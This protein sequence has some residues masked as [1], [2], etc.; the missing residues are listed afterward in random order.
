MGPVVR[1]H[2]AK[3]NQQSIRCSEEYRPHPVGTIDLGEGFECLSAQLPPVP[4]TL[5]AALC[6]LSEDE[7]ARANRFVFAHDRDRFIMARGLLRQLLGERL[8]IAPKDIEFRYNQFGKPELADQCGGNALRFNVSHSEDFVIFVFA[9]GRQV[10]ADIEAIRPLPDAD[11]VAARCFSPRE[12]DAY[13]D[14]D[15]AM[16]PRGFFN[17]WTR[18]E[19]FVK[20][21]GEGLGYRLSDFDVSLAPGDP[22][23]ILRVGELENGNCGWRMFDIDGIPGFAGAVVIESQNNS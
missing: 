20:A 16:K 21:V 11:E 8:G 7:R 4:G 1:L 12:I 6:S 22:A 5:D 15:E 2:R 14:L 18:K 19:A 13:R 23:E 10:G 3:M 9:R 17:C